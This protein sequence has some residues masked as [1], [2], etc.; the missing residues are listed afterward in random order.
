MFG[1]KNFPSELWRYCSSVFQLWVLLLRSPMLSR[2]TQLCMWSVLL[3][4]SLC[5]SLGFALWAQC[6]L[7]CFK[8]FVIFLK[9]FIY[10]SLSWVFVSEWAFSL[11]SGQRGYSL[12]VGSRL[13]IAVV[14]HV[15]DHGHQGAL[16]SV[17]LARGLSCSAACGLFTEQG[18]SACLLHWQVDSLPLSHQ[19]NPVF[20]SVM[21]QLPSRFSRVRLCVTP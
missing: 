8:K 16:A 7:F 4:L 14:S 13:F 21:L 12:I 2:S 11:A 3:F 6:F 18:S 10:F 15:V 20:Y 9:I 17:V 1:W 19:G 5:G